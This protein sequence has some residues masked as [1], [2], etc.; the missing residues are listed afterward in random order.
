[1]TY[2]KVLHEHYDFASYSSSADGIPPAGR[3]LALDCATSLATADSR[4]PSPFQD[5]SMMRKLLKDMTTVHIVYSQPKDV[6]L[7]D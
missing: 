6:L 1:M 5:T 4:H 3:S 7:S 2:G